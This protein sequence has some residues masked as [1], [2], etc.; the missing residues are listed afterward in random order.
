VATKRGWIAEVSVWASYA[1]TI[2][3]VKLGGKL[4]ILYAHI[5][6]NEK[7]VTYEIIIG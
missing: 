5:W 7:G 2:K 1:M 3:N 6:R 4:K